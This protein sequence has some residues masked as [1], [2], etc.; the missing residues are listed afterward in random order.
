MQ[1]LET[2]KTS[3]FHYP[4]IEAKTVASLGCYFAVW[5]SSPNVS[6]VSYKETKDRKKQAM[7]KWQLYGI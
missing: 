2:Q 1:A 7:I 5:G 6:F 3:A 4:S